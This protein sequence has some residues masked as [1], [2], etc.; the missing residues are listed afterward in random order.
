MTKEELL[1]RYAA[2]E[3]NFFK[4][5]LA[6]VSLA[7]STLPG[8]DLSFANL[9]G[10]NLSD[11]KMPGSSF[12]GAILEGVYAR[13]AIFT[14]CNFYMA[15]FWVTGQS[16]KEARFYSCDF[17]RC[18]LVDLEA[19]NVI[20]PYSTFDGA[21]IY[22]ANF[23]SGRLGFTSWQGVKFNSTDFDGVDIR[24]STF[25][26]ADFSGV[27]DHFLKTARITGCD[28]SRS[29]VT[30]NPSLYDRVGDPDYCQIWLEEL[31]Q[32]AALPGRPDDRNWG[33]WDPVPDPDNPF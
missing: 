13:D 29:V 3:R 33:Q 14:D 22:G 24:Q 11:V 26:E 5:D 6:G 4:A 17:T 25:H 1:E 16:L 28:F 2:G 12:R 30:S 31:R 18:N 20:A 10:A 21:N 23:N 19:K 9:T 8:I 32:K 7:G 27:S 15:K